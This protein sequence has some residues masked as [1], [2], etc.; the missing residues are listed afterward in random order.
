MPD[1]RFLD[2]FGTGS[3]GATQK[4]CLKLNRKCR[5][6]DIP[7]WH[8]S[9]VVFLAS[10][11][12]QIK[13]RVKIRVNPSLELGTILL[14]KWYPRIRIWSRAVCANKNWPLTSAILKTFNKPNTPRAENG[15]IFKNLWLRSLESIFDF[16]IARVF[17]PAQKRYKNRRSI[18]PTFWFGKCGGFARS[19]TSFNLITILTSFK[20]YCV[21]RLDSESD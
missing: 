20:K 6:R 19:L 2:G 9:P 14:Q 21:T 4:T 3:T 15:D 10:K 8:F 17:S 11:T 18:V 12:T 13:N 1:L 5:T 16:L 7:Q